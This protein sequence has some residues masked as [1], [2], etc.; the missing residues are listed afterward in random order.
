MSKSMHKHPMHRHPIMVLHDKRLKGHLPPIRGYILETDEDSS[1]AASIHSLAS[2]A[3][4]GRGIG[5]PK[6]GHKTSLIGEGHQS[7]L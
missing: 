7:C 4:L 5:N 6:R 1:V 3:K 2:W